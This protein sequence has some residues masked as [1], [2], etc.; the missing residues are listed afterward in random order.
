MDFSY[1]QNILLTPL[2]SHVY[3]N[4]FEE[5]LDGAEPLRH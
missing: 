5:E 2:S 4:K 3:V 1:Q